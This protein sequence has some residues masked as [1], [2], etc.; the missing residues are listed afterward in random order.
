MIDEYMAWKASQAEPWAKS[1][2]K[3]SQRLMAREEALD[4]LRGRYD[5]LKATRYDSQGGGSPTTGD[6][7]MVRFISQLEEMTA[8]WADALQ[9]WAEEVREFEAALRRM[10]AQHDYVLTAHYLRGMTWDYIARVMS[11]SEVYVRKEVRTA[12]LAALY[13]AMPPHMRSIPKAEED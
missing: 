2:R 7:A 5:G 12:A 13:D 4:E 1:I 6:D 11:Y 9:E 10:D 3:T 8:D